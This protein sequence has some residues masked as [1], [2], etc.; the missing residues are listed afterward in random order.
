M[1]K[2]TFPTFHR[3]SQVHFHQSHWYSSVPPRYT[4]T[5]PTGKLFQTLWKTF[6]KPNLFSVSIM[7]SQPSITVDTAIRIVLHSVEVVHFPHNYPG[8]YRVGILPA[9]HLCHDKLPNITF[10][11]HPLV[12]VLP[13]GLTPSQHP[14]STPPT[15]SMSPAPRQKTHSNRLAVG[16]YGVL[17]PPTRTT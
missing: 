11:L 9:Y 6:Y 3:T 7:P 4:S 10:R 12:W 1:T 17:P 13:C 2:T 16:N 8:V 14:G 5:S 15:S